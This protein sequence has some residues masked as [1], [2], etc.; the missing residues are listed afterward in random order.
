MN[1]QT[2]DRKERVP[3]K[4]KWIRGLAAAAVGLFAAF[5]IPEAVQ[6]AEPKTA[7]EGIYV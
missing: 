6:A 7:L 2:H 1:F 4:K 5:G 3:M